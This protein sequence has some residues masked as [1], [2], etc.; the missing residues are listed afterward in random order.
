[1]ISHIAKVYVM[2]SKIKTNKQLRN[3]L[4]FTPEHIIHIL[5]SI[6]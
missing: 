5:G 3:K 1:M 2:L 4:N 6:C